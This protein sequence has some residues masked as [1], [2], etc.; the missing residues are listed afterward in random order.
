[1]STRRRSL[2]GALW[3]KTGKDVCAG[4]KARTSAGLSQ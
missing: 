4:G 2:K 3:Q 1:M